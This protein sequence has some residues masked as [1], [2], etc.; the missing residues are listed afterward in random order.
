MTL[1]M[2][3]GTGSGNSNRRPLAADAT[4][5]NRSQS[6]M[7]VQPRTYRLAIGLFGDHPPLFRA[8]DD[9]SGQGL[10]ADCLC[11]IGRLERMSP[12]KIGGFDR[13]TSQKNGHLFAG[14]REVHG[15]FPPAPC[16]ASA[17]RLFDD[18]CEPLSFPVAVPERYPMWL[19]SSQYERLSV[20]V[21]E[22][23]LVLIVSSATPAQQDASSRILLR[24]SQHGVQT[25]DFTVRPKGVA[26]G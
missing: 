16:A 2:L 6:P 3:D 12:E 23:G 10:A 24:H 9:L 21:F 14:A 26:H 19:T 11:L 13:E 17:G 1:S 20:H 25:H 8:L 22:G 7:H 4:P 5:V 18:L 15:L